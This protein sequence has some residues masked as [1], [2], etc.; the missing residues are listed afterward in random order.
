GFDGCAHRV[1]VAL[2]DAAD[3]LGVE[4][5]VQRRRA[6]QISEHDGNDLAHLGLV[7]G[8]RPSTRRVDRAQDR[9]RTG[10]ERRPAGNAESGVAL[11]LGTARQATRC[12]RRA[13]AGAEPRDRRIRSPAARAAHDG[14]PAPAF[15]VTPLS[16]W[17][18]LS[19]TIALPK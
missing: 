2:H 16:A 5:L 10:S 19:P 1:V 13:A 7:R 11:V 8:G 12:E 4:T 3:R 17:T 14:T 18:K 6:D 9:G 15:L